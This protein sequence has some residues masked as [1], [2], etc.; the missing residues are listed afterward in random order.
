MRLNALRELGDRHG[1]LLFLRNMPLLGAPGLGPYSFKDISAAISDN[2]G[3]ANQS[4]IEA[5]LNN[6]DTNHL[7]S[8]TAALQQALGDLRAIEAQVTDKLGAGQS[9]RFEELTNLL[10]PM[11]RLL[12]VRLATRDPGTRVG[13]SGEPDTT[14]EGQMT[15]STSAAH[16]HNGALRP[17]GSGPMEIRT[18]ADVQRTLDL[19]CAYYESNE[20]SSPVPILL[21][22][23]RRL[24]AMSFMDLVRDLA[25][26]GAA[27]LEVIRGPQ[28]ADNT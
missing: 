21:R 8:L 13:A 25:P 3:D 11:H 20:P 17:V 19:L 27:E 12:A 4:K 16:A 18:R 2:A 10:D 26:A 28:E 15:Q 23:A 5:A 6:C 1:V 24:T 22:R 9:I 7:Q 14:G